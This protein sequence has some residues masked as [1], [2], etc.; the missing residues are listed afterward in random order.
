MF[1][2]ADQIEGI[3]NL[4]IGQ[5]DFNTP[6]HIREAAKV[7]LDQGYTRYPPAKGFLDLRQAI[8]EKLQLKNNM[9][10]DPDTNIFVAVGAMQVIFNTILHLIEPGDEVMVIDPGYDYYSQ[11]GLFGGIPVRIPAREENGFKTDA[12][13]VKKA[14]TSKTKL[15]A[16]NTPSNPTGAVL[17]AE[18]LNALADIAQRHGLL[19]FA[20]EPYEDIIFDKKNI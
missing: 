11:I 10:T 9:H 2:L 15:M 14:V 19:V 7:A 12:V 4:G 13:D 1:A 3:V 5:P 17:D 8:A 18:I 6:F 16:I 20:D